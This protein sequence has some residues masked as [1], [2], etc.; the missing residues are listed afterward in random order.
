MM[1]NMVNEALMVYRTKRSGKLGWVDTLFCILLG[2]MV[3]LFAL[4]VECLG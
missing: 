4:I 1:A 2:S 3:H